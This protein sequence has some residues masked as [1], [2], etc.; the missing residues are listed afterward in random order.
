MIDENK[1]V[2]LS[3]LICEPARAKMLWALLDGNAYTASELSVVADV[4]FTSTSNHLNK[5]LAA[6]LLRVE[7][8]GKYRYFSFSRP[9]VA[10][11][12]EAL[13]NLAKDDASLIKKDRAPIGIKYCR[14]CYDHLAGEVG[15]KMVDALVRQKLIARSEMQFEVTAK[16]WRWFGVLGI[17]CDMMKNNRRQHVI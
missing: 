7:A 16:G 6:D 17:E 11:A 10:Y 14:S 13:A 1:F 5:L 9:E 15:V 12:V 2:R 8:R 4:S 3:A